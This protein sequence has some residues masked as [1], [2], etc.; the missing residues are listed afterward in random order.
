MGTED[1]RL[2][3]LRRHVRLLGDLLDGKVLTAKFVAERQGIGEANARR[4][5]EALEDLRGVAVSRTRPREYRFEFARLTD[6]PDIP[7]SVAACFGASLAGLFRGT[8]YE[9]GLRRALDHVLKHRP[10][11]RFA[12]IDRKFHFLSRG[13]EFDIAKRQVELD[14]VIDA[15]LRSNWINLRYERFKG[16]IDALRLRPLCVL[17]YQQQ[18]YVLADEGAGTTPHPYRFSRIKKIRVETRKF[19]YP[20]T[21]SFNPEQLFAHSFGVFTGDDYPVRKVRFV[22]SPKWLPFVTSHKWNATQT[23]KPLGDGSVQVDIRVRTCPE[24]VSWLA[25]LG[26]DVE[27]KIP[28][29]LAATVRELHVRALRRTPRSTRPKTLSTADAHSA[30]R[31]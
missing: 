12:N 26:E 6:V 9:G 7:T 30:L 27:I 25:G 31:R 11:A 15:V 29:D 13:G 8:P 1:S 10:D 4:Q 22:L 2:K 16:Q 5:L 28:R 21:A 20:T 23:T 17:V 18:L 14:E 3:E 19:A 24:L